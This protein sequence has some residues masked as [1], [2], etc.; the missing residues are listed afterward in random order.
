[1]KNWALWTIVVLLSSSEVRADTVCNWIETAVAA[2]D[3]RPMEGREPEQMAIR[4]R[5]ALAMFEAL[6]A[7]SPQYES[8]L[9]IRRTTK[10]ASL[11]AAAATA[12]YEV[13]LARSPGFRDLLDAAYLVSRSTAK[14][15]EE[16]E[17]GRQIGRLAAK[18][19]LE[20]PPIDP[21]V[22]QKPYRPRTSPGVWVMTG[23]PYYQPIDLAQKPWVLKGAS[24]I[25]PSSPP[26]LNSQ[27]WA[28]DYDEV[29]QIGAKKSATR[30]PYQTLLVRFWASPDIGTLLR[31]LAN[32]P[33]RSL[34]Q[35]ARLFTLA[36]MAL[37]D[38]GLAAAEA[39]MHYEFWRPITAIRN[40]DAD[41]NAATTP[42]PGWEPLL[43]TPDHPEFPCAHCVNA[44]ALATVLSAEFGPTPVGGVRFVKRQMPGVVLTLPSFQAYV[45]ATSQSRIS[46]GVHYRFSTD[47]GDEMGKRIGEM[48]VGSV[49]LPKATVTRESTSVRKP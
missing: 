7:I 22:T 37:D 20:R 28:R 13:L 34:L 9:G 46:A 41:G 19:A 38:A 17:A 48:V 23:L 43:N 2:T 30:S 4:T 15:Q 49:L 14:D 44:S 21:N 26:A 8:Y 11:D 16:W 18:A 25:R 29:K 5:V 40:G 31:G 24:A 32:A 3:P 12:A 45:A 27:R 1:M 36:Y 10:R 47:A 35:N 33:G 39:K 42:D 6:N